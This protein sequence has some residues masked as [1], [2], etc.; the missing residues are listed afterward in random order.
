M[1]PFDSDGI[2]DLEAAEATQPQ[3]PFDEGDAGD[4]FQD[5]LEGGDGFEDAFDA[6]DSDA[7]SE[8]LEADAAVDLGEGFEEGADDMAVWNAFEEEVADALDAADDDEFLGRLLGGLGRAAGVVGRG[9]GAAAGAAGQARGFARRAGRVAGQ[10]GRVAGAVSPAAAAAAQLARLLGAPGLAS[11]LSQVGSAAQAVQGGARRARGIAGSLGQAAGGMQG[12]FGQLS[13]LIGQGF[14]EFDAFDAMVDLYEEGADEALPAA[15][16]L[17]ARA[18]ARG[19]GFRNVA[20]LSE[21]GRRALVRGVG[22]AARELARTGRPGMVR[23]L[24][25]LVTSGARVA[26]RRVP[27]PQGAVQTL[28]RGLPRAAQRVARTPALARRLAHTPARP[29]RPLS[30]PTDVGRGT[31]GAR[32]ASGPRTYRFRGPI[33]LTITPR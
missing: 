4:G 30:R 6:G 22:A 5:E 10:V 18:A 9:I 24:P 27:T 17:A 3:S 7:A 8:E 14:D 16:A 1:T 2:D 23:A 15:V 19:L 26:Q 20:Q 21:A 31:P 12:L 25:R 28:R 32:P 13:Q 11:G 33:T 29:T